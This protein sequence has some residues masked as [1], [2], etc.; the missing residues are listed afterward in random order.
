MITPVILGSLSIPATAAP[1][2]PALFSNLAGQTVE[3]TLET[4]L[5]GGMVLRLA[6]GKLLQAQG[7]LPFPEGSALTL[8]T[9]PLPEGAGLR[10]QVIRATPPASPAL[11]SPLAHGEAGPLLARLQ[12][13]EAQSS[14]AALFRGLLQAGTA[15]AEGSEA[16]ASW[17]KAAMRTLADPAASTA[18]SAFHRL[19]AKE[20]TGWFELPLPWAP[21]AEPLRIWIERDQETA[22]NAAET[23]HRVFLSVPFSALGDIRLGLE[24][25]SSGLRV[26]LWLQ[27]PEQLAACRAALEAELVT[28][29]RPVDLQI[30]ALPP[31]TPDL[32]A[33]AGASPLQALG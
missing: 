2:A 11:L 9:L 26:R 12:T 1:S 28:L 33:L 16:W 25:R 5:P 4:L 19:Q 8:S 30:F 3:A 10:L 6:D 32:R 20:D 27:D 24:Q 15:V 23:V 13:T 31:G 22:G 18:E 29:G 7:S 14:L 21:G 17:M